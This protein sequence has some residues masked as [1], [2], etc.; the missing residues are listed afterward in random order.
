[1]AR[2]S[3]YA[4]EHHKAV[5]HSAKIFAAVKKAFPKGA[6]VKIVANSS[7]ASASYPEFVGALGEVVEHDEGSPFDA[8]PL[9][10]VR[11][12]KPIRGIDV[13]SFTPDE[14]VISHK[15]PMSHDRAYEVRRFRF[16]RDCI[17]RALLT[18]PW[19]TI[20]E[21]KLVGYR[22]ALDRIGTCGDSDEADRAAVARIRDLLEAE[23][24]RHVKAGND[25]KAEF[26][27]GFG[28]NLVEFCEQIPRKK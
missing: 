12:Q 2:T 9:I 8:S 19:A 14:L 11:F 6:Q 18:L 22:A 4:P 17:S 7:H 24:Q 5:R 27:L 20:T 25:G 16:L 23:A 15:G 13:E 1:M 10:G 3:D 28:L 26:L 21:P